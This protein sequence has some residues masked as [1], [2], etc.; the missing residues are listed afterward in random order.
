[1]LR[2]KVYNQSSIYA[3]SLLKLPR[4]VFDG[5]ERKKSEQKKGLNGFQRNLEEIFI[6]ETGTSMSVTTQGSPPFFE[7][8]SHNITFWADSSLRFFNVVISANEI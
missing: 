2:T 7:G 6:A 5:P 8:Q 3:A 1:M 4:P